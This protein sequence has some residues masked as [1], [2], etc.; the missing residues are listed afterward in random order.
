MVLTQAFLHEDFQFNPSR[1][2]LGFD[3]NLTLLLLLLIQGFL[4]KKHSCK[5]DLVAISGPRHSKIVFTLLYEVV[6]IYMR[7]T[8][9]DVGSLRSESSL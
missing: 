9:I 6:A 4:L 1:G 5:G 3:I 8:F 7:F 2:H